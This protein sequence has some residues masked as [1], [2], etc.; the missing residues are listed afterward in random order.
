MSGGNVRAMPGSTQPRNGL[1]PSRGYVYRGTGREMSPAEITGHLR[2]KIRERQDMVPELR[3][4]IY[5]ATL[6]TPSK[7]RP[8]RVLAGANAGI[9]EADRR[10]A[11]ERVLPALEAEPEPGET[12]RCP[13]CG[14]LL[15]APG[16][17]ITCGGAP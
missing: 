4:Y 3:P 9:T 7:G 5:G 1:P 15:T 13:D 2:R 8:E 6:G 10:P 11:P 17:K 12:G 16:H 14:Y